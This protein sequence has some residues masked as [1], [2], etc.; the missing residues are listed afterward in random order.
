MWFDAQVKTMFTGRVQRTRKSGIRV[1][2]E[3]VA[4]R[5]FLG[6]FGP[7]PFF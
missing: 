1:I 6:K 7:M 4:A 3:I 5:L 2:F